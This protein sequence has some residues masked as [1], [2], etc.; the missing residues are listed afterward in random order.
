MWGLQAAAPKSEGNISKE[1]ET[2]TN[3]LIMNYVYC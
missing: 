3:W 2:H 1:L